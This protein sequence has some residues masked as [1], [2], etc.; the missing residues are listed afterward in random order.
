MSNKDNLVPSNQLPVDLQIKPQRTGSRARNEQQR[1]RKS[2]RISINEMLNRKM[3]NGKTVQDNL[4]ETLITNSM[5]TGNIS[6]LVKAL[7]FL[8][9]TSGQKQMTGTLNLIQNQPVK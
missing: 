3:S 8:C 5:N 7:T 9:E 1:Q 2:M 4:L 6:D